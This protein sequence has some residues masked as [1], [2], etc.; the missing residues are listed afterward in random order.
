MDSEIF[1]DYVRKLDTKF[2]AE[3]R[4]IVLIIDNCP[5]HPNVDNLR[6][7]QLVFLPPNTT[8]KTQ[9]MDQ[10]VIRALKPFYRTNVVR[11]QI[12]YVDEGKTT[13][14]INILQAMRM[15]VKSW[16]ATSINT[17]DLFK[18]DFQLFEH[19]VIRTKF[20]TPVEVRITGSLLYYLNGLNLLLNKNFE[21]LHRFSKKW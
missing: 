8:S 7:I 19:S 20:L 15:L 13:P 14:K 18:A 9:P 11:R 10:G 2:D 12:K 3:G 16:D 5:A 17:V 6:A 1:S 4:K 21:F